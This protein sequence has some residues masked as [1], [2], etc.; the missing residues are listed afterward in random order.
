MQRRIASAA[1]HLGFLLALAL[2]QNAPA[3]AARQ[4]LAIPVAGP[5]PATLSADLFTPGG[6]GPHPTVILLHGC[7]GVTRSVTAWAAWLV[8][9]GYGALVLDSFSGRGLSTVCGHPQTLTGDVRASDV[10][11]A[12][13]R[14][15]AVTGV[16]GTRIAAMGF[17]H[18]G[19]TAVW[20]WRTQ[21]RHPEASI[22]TLIAFYPACG[23]TLPAGDAPPLLMLLGGRDDWT[24]PEPCL[25]MAD[26]ARKAGRA[27]SVVVYP[28]ARHAFD[29]ANLLHPVHVA[30]ARG[31]KGATIEYD[32]NA[33][34]DA[35]IQVRQFLK[36]QLGP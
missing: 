16:D 5:Q 18:G 33:H 12:V 6:A 11:A 10:F 9:E 28:E 36:A 8:S 31:G 25:K 27:V 14:L 2:A 35:E 15:K 21:D 13:A 32:P 26:A 7:S 24:P 3:E 20:A 30:V 34:A 29:A 17:S 23:P 19:W 4:S 1:R 22:R